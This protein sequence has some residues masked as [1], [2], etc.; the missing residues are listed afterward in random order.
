MFR[1]NLREWL[2]AL[3]HQRDGVIFTG[4]VKLE[5]YRDGVCLYD[6]WE[7]KPNIFTTAGMAYLLNV[8]FHDISKAASNIWYVGIFKN[9]VTPAL[10]D[11]AAAKLGAGG[12]YGECQDADYD[13]P[14]TNKPSYVPVDTATAVITNAASKAEFTIAASITVYGAFLSTVAAKTATTGYLMCAKAFAASRAVVDND[15]LAITYQITASSS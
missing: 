4:N 3:K 11:T 13:S 15:V 6:A 1:K 5:H 9:N 14:A 2:Y 10:G 7:P 8:M 12:D